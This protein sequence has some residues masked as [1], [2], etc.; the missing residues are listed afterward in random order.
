[1]CGIFGFD[2]WTPYTER[3]LGYGAMLIEQRGRQSWGLTNGRYLYKR[4]ERIVGNFKVPKKIYTD[5]DRGV[6]VHTRAASVGEVSYEN[7]HPFLVISKD[8]SRYVIGVHNGGISNYEKLGKESGFEHDVDSPHLFRWI[9]DGRNTR[10]VTGWGAIVW[11]EGPTQKNEKGE[12]QYCW[13][14]GK[15][16]LARFNSENL[17]VA[18]LKTGEIVYGSTQDIVET[19]I[20]AAGAKLSHFYKVEGDMKYFIDD[21]VL[22]EA[23]RMPFGG[24][25]ASAAQVAVTNG[26]TRYNYAGYQTG[27][28][29]QHESVDHWI[30]RYEER[31]Q[32]EQVPT[33][34]WKP[35]TSMGDPGG[36]S[37]L[38]S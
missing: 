1:M 29:R 31:H 10:E 37:R 7:T 19:A 15:Q 36:W 35:M 38:V 3:I 16:Y 33:E 23:G 4:P 11:W 8:Q 26:H 20:L 21:G 2:K 32:R 18:K 28:S 30:K 24:R 13:S 25:A 6:V 5:K 14:E 27:Q 9:A 34:N 12:L 17:A 22:R